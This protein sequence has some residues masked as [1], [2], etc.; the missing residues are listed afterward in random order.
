[1]TSSRGVKARKRERK[2]KTFFLSLAS[3]TCFILGHSLPRCVFTTA[4]LKPASVF[5]CDLP[6]LCERKMLNAVKIILYVS[7]KP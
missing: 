6:R 4:S 1:M 7:L 3:L 5:G 2:A